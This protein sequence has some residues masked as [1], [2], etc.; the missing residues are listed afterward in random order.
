MNG[1]FEREDVSKKRSFKD[2]IFYGYIELGH[3]IQSIFID[4]TFKKII[5]R[6]K[7]CIKKMIKN[8]IKRFIMS[9]I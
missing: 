7:L 9:R 6:K 2:R 1:T 5:M 4:G 3:F 8:F